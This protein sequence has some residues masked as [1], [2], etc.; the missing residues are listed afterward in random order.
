VTHSELASYLWASEFRSYGF[1]AQT[2]G[3]TRL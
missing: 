2:A 1:E 3:T